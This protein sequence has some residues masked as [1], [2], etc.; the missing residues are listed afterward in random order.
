MRTTF[1]L[2]FLTLILYETNS[3]LRISF[4]KETWILSLNQIL[5]LADSSQPLYKLGCTYPMPSYAN[6]VPNINPSRHPSFL[7]VVAVLLSPPLFQS[8]LAQLNRVPVVR[9]Q[10]PNSR[11]KNHVES[12]YVASDIYR[13]SLAVISHRCCDFSDEHEVHSMSL[14]SSSCRNLTPRLYGSKIRCL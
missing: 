5:I 8:S 1:L 10:K 7:I 12:R 11:R 9:S 4:F 2:L 6:F 13:Q 3:N 14:V